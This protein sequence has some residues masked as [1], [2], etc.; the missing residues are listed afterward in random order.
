MG[1]AAVGALGSLAGGLAGKAIMGDTSAPA[2]GGIPG[3]TA[4]KGSGKDG[5]TGS[6]VQV[7]PTIAIEYF[8][9]SAIANEKNELKG[10]QFY[11]AAVGEAITTVQQSTLQANSTLQPLS[12]ASNQALNQQLRMLGM[13][14]I[15]ATANASARLNAL[16]PNFQGLDPTQ[17]A[18]I[19]SLST[20]LDSAANIS[21]PQARAA[22]LNQINE[23]INGITAGNISNLQS[24]IQA[25]QAVAKPSASSM[26]SLGD[27]YTASGG[28]TN[29]FGRWNVPYDAVENPYQPGNYVRKAD[30][31]A[32]MAKQNQYSTA[33]KQLKDYQAQ[34]EAQQSN[35][36]QLN[37]FKD[38]YTQ[39]YN[40]GYDSAYT[41]EQAANV[42][43]STPGYQFQFDQ[44]NQALQRQQAA[45]GMLQSGNA[46][47]AAVKYGQDFGMSYYDKYMQQ[48]NNTVNQGASA[49]AQISANQ[50][51]EGTGIAGLQQSVGQVGSDT[52]S[53]IGQ[54]TGN[55]LQQ[56]G[57]L[58]QQAALANMAAQN[59]QAGDQQQNQMQAAL[60]N[61]AGQQRAASQAQAGA[62]ALLGGRK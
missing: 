41:G 28:Q 17:K 15:Q 27:A 29:S 31:D 48:L 18:Q 16:V 57:I 60:A 54:Y 46:M 52:Y 32:F 25:A 61:A 14:P 26:T 33:Q 43:K 35:A 30:Y 42:I 53:R 8:K 55:S 6:V 56:S 58:F 5:K 3:L 9:Q 62:G 47:T 7:D 22:T 59:K 45:A 20:Q 10:L 50:A 38:S 13:Q 24:K 11:S 44:G 4:S 37:A 21:D 2:G 36:S 1:L 19:A 40:Q 49:T 12:T 51:A 39:Q 23:S 34:L